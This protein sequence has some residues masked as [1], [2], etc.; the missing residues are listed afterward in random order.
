MKEHSFNWRCPY[1]DHVQTDTVN[2]DQGPFLNLTCGD[3]LKVVDEDS[4]DIKSAAN[5]DE[6]CIAAEADE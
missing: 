2:K 3:C 4:L 1:C 6:A 5:W